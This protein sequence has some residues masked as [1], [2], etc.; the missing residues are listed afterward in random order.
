[1]I[2]NKLQLRWVFFSAM[3]TLEKDWKKWL[4]ILLLTITLQP[5]TLFASTELTPSD[6]IILSNR[7]DMDFCSD[8][9]VFMKQLSIDWICI[10]TLEL[11][12]DTKEKNVILVGGP[13][14]AYTGDIVK[15][16]ITEEEADLIRENRCNTFVKDSP[17][18]D[19]RVVYICAGSDRILTKIAAEKTIQ[20]L[21]EKSKK[22]K[23]WVEYPVLGT[24]FEE[25]QAYINHFQFIPEDGELAREELEYEFA[26]EYNPTISSEDAR[27]DVE[28]LF[29]LLSYGYCGYGYFESKEDFEGAKSDILRELETSSVWSL[30][31][32]SSLIHIHLHV[33]TDGHLAVGHHRYFDHTTF[34]TN[35][36][37]EFW[38]TEGIYYFISDEKRW[39][40]LHINTDDP[41][42][43]LYPSLNSRG[44]P[45]YILGV[46]S[47]DTP[48]PFTL[49]VEDEKGTAD[50]IQI[51]LYHIRFGSPKEPGMKIFEEKSISGIP[52]LC[53]REF[54][55]YHP[56]EM[57]DFLHTA[58][59]YRG[60][61]YLILDIRD[62][63]GG[64]DEWAAK[65]VELFTGYTPEGYFAETSL[66]S[67]TTLLGKI[68]VW[69]S[70]LKDYP[71]NKA[72]N[73]YLKEC[74]ED[75]RIF[76]ASH[77]TPYWSELY[78]PQIHMIPNPTKVIVLQD[79]G[80][81][82]SGESFIGFL[83]QVK[84]VVFVGE[85]SAGV[86]MFGYYTLHQLPFSKL[87]VQLG[88]TLYFPVDLQFM[89]GE[90][91]YPDLWIPASDVLNFV[92]TAVENG[93][94]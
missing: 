43:Y 85:N 83:R 30:E 35:K 75:L 37:Y 58:E 66:V 49:T 71:H 73:N 7:T 92:I 33:I 77:S 91:F 18:A 36:S 74:E 6:T 56:G 53:L 93:I 46:L 32:F 2:K 54:S 13:D 34:Y 64:N 80:T 10:N 52:I 89:E 20:S 19:N 42:K 59:K 68:N 14:A 24:S 47:Q 45:V 60:V 67:R 16:L 39:K 40:V 50:S 23:E 84:S 31:D 63:P 44:E 11:P 3:S 38:K 61:S 82:S 81:A 21:V 90:G 94:I 12:V 17:W 70:F 79:G 87:R 62:N 48:T 27:K 22:P 9:S 57:E 5:V 41:E 51:G 25:A 28:R 29:Y 76:E 1:M 86:C 15:D 72:F 65:W 88:T 69:D 4:I 26:Y 78:F 8:F 55:D